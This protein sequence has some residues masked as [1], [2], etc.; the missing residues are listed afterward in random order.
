[1]CALVRSSLLSLAFA[2]VTFAM[3]VEAADGPRFTPP[4]NR[5]GQSAWV[6]LRHQ[7]QERNL[8]VPTSASIILDYFGDS[9]S[10]R[11]IKELSLNK[12]YAPGDKFTDFSITFFRDLIAGLARRGYG[13]HEKTYRNDGRGLRK[14]LSEIE[15]SL[16][17]GI[18]VMIDTTTEGGHTF[19]V[20][21]Y[22]IPNQ[23]LLAVDP[24]E[25]FPG[26]REVGFAELD[27]I[28]NS[29]AVGFN[30]RA[31]VYPQ[32]RGQSRNGR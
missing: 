15:R 20:A 31:A 12:P 5:A 29:S 28:W 8:C 6:Q 11:E 32:R 19:V 14:G 22:S 9:I 25:P 7:H 16:D 21:G 27:G 4:P 26:I 30:G 3:C 18:P 23:T 17:A 13:W 1:M 10:P 2:C 24:A